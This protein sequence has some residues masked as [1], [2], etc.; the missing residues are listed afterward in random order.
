MSPS[1]IDYG[2]AHWWL[3]P[4]RC[5]QLHLHIF[6]IACVLYVGVSMLLPMKQPMELA[7]M[8]LALPYNWSSLCVR[9]ATQL[10]NSDCC[11]WHKKLLLLL[12]AD[13][14]AVELKGWK[15]P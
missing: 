2:C 10:V 3:Q 7:Q 8:Q 9:H 1:Q 5:S 12:L 14:T 4:I 15:F 13:E 11:C 6:V